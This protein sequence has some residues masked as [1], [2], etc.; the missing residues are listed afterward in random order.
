MSMGIIQVLNYLN[1]QLL[2]YL[3]VE[4]V[5]Q[6]SQNLISDKFQDYKFRKCFEQCIIYFLTLAL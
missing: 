1:E 6:S 5:K 2:I 4:F 3:N